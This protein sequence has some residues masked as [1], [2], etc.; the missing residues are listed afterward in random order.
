MLKRLRNKSNWGW[1]YR[2][3][4]CRISGD[5]I[6]NWGRNNNTIWISP[7]HNADWHSAQNVYDSFWISGDVVLIHQYHVSDLPWAATKCN[8]Q[9]HINCLT[10]CHNLMLFYATFIART[11]IERSNHN[12]YHGAQNEMTV[13]AFLSLDW[14][15][16]SDIRK[17]FGY[18][19]YFGLTTLQL[20]ECNIVADVIFWHCQFLSIYHSPTRSITISLVNL[21]STQ[22]WAR[23]KSA[24]EE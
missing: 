19:N 11:C 18:F 3:S 1:H 2:I 20:L 15:N 4:Y 9:A 8:L 7:W 13:V 14:N 6:S 17:L 12:T 21:R 24:C 23:S 22:F 10:A 16:Y 5:W